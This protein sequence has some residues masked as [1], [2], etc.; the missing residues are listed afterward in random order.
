MSLKSRISLAN[1]EGEMDKYNHRAR[2]AISDEYMKCLKR[3]TQ[4]VRDL[5]EIATKLE[6]EKDV[7]TYNKYISLEN[8]ASRL[9]QEIKTEKIKS[10]VWDMAREICLN[11]VDEVL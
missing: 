9:H 5:E 11:I 3:K 8:E 1:L 6:E 7:L 2:Q 10:D 4:L